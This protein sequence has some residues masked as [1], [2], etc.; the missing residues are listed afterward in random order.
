MRMY[1]MYSIILYFNIEHTELFFSRT[2]RMFLTMPELY[3]LARWTGLKTTPSF[4]YAK[5]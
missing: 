1:Q 5:R 3:I 4:C 2:G